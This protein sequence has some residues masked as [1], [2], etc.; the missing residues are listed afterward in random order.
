MFG[1]SVLMDQTVEH[2]ARHYGE[3]DRGNDAWI[4]EEPV[5]VEYCSVQPLDSVE[6]LTAAADQTVSRWQ[7]FGP[8]DMGLKGTDW[9]KADGTTYEVD[10]ESS[11][12]RSVAPFLTHTTAILKEV[13]G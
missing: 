7:F 10:G 5:E 3:D 11:V 9:I 13:K 6:Y 8:P 12:A 4:E 1:R 2:I